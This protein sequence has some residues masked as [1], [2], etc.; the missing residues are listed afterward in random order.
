M[1]LETIVVVATLAAGLSG[2]HAVATAA[3]AGERRTLKGA[4]GF[5]WP[6][7]FVGIFWALLLS[8][9]PFTSITPPL[10]ASYNSSAAV[11][12]QLPILATNLSQALVLG[13]VLEVVSRLDSL[14]DSEVAK[15]LA[16]A[17]EIAGRLISVQDILHL[18]ATLAELDAGTSVM[19]VLLSFFSL[20]NLMWIVSIFGLFMTA[21]YALS[22]L[23]APIASTLASLWELYL[24][25]ALLVCQP[26]YEP[27]IYVMSVVVAIEAA[28]HQVSTFTASGAMIGLSAWAVFWLGLSYTAHLELKPM[29]NMDPKPT[30]E[31]TWNETRR[32]YIK[33]SLLASFVAASL[34]IQHQSPFMGFMAVIS[35]L[36]SMGFSAFA[37]PLCIFIGFG[38]ESET[39]R[40]LAVSGFLTL[41]NMSL[42][43]TRLTSHEWVAPFQPALSIMGTSVFL[44]A[45]NIA[46][47]LLPY[48]HDR[49]NKKSPA[50]IFMIFL[51]YMAVYFS[52]T[53]FCVIA[54]TLLGLDGM[55][56]VGKVYAAIFFLTLFC[57]VKPKDA[58]LVSFWWFALF[59]ILYGVS[60][61]LSANPQYLYAL[62]GG[63]GGPV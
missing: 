12:R 54:G 53:I 57:C 4:A 34:A 11:E 48:S 46:T 5:V 27:L 39:L 35:L 1:I 30:V 14:P 32:V 37:M 61:T 28:R 40:C 9:Q 31:E 51:R 3:K 49:A 50:E 55:A 22:I 41:V 43:V 26:A 60:M 42:Q 45:M 13:R 2:L 8:E 20:V 38:S 16:T 52:L 36:H 15:A 58:G 6:L 21:Q 18:P 62:V 23:L 63:I 19:D 24:Y 7:L 10:F 29:L 59:C 56:N 25:P 33:A 47:I 17:S 44:L